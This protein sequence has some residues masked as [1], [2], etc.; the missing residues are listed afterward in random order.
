MER[1]GAPTAIKS[2]NGHCKAV[3]KTHTGFV[4]RT[5]YDKVTQEAKSA[6]CPERQRL[7]LAL[8][9]SLIMLVPWLV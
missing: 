1:A 9:T 7:Y 5:V 4:S 6:S 3:R 8:Q 2:L